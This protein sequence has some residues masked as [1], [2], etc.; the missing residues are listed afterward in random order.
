MTF[1]NCIV[2]FTCIG[3][4]KKL[5]L[6]NEQKLQDERRLAEV[7]QVF[8]NSERMKV[9]KLNLPREANKVKKLK[10]QLAREIRN[11]RR[12]ELKLANDKRKGKRMEKRNRK[13]YIWK[14]K[15]LSRFGQSLYLITE[16]ILKD[17]AFNMT[18]AWN[19]E[20]I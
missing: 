2:S 5:R 19:E 12:M 9:M 15:F 1:M 16:E 4:M 17:K 11:R 18:R 20:K 8:H 6:E 7:P 13:S 3:Q 10:M 14:V